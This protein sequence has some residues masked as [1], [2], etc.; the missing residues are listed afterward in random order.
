MDI[1]IVDPTRTYMMQQTSTTTT[2]VTTMATQEK[3]MSYAERTLGDDF[4]PFAFET[5][6]C[7]HFCFDS[8]FTVCACITITRHQ[9]SFSVSSILIS[10]YQQ[11]VSITL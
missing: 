8:F 6:G 4:I 2:H 10:H 11:R 1:V 7:F 5:Y 3:T 9:Q